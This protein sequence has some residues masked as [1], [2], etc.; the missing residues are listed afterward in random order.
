M[1]LH[2]QKNQRSPDA[3]HAEAAPDRRGIEWY[4]S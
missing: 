2:I 4:V 3:R 1:I